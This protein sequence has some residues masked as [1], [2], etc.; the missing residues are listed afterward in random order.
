[1]PSLGAD[2]DEGTVL[3]WLV[4]PGATVH[5]GDIV[6]V[7]KTDKA[8]IEVE[9]FDD[10]VVGEL[11]VPVGETVAVGTPLA[12][13]LDGEAG[14]APTVT[15]PPVAPAPEAAPAPPPSAP[16]PAPRP[17][18]ERARVSPYARRLA[19]ERGVDVA[20]IRTDHGAPVLAA[21]VERA[22]ERAPARPAAPAAPLDQASAM[23]RAIANLMARSKREIPHYYLRLQCDMTDALG[24]LERVNAEQPVDR[25]ALPAVL[26]CKATAVAARTYP[27]LNGFWVD[28][29]FVPGTGVHLGVAI[30][31][32]GGG[33]IAPA[34]HDADALPLPDLMAALRDLTLRARSGRLRASEMSDATLTVTSLGDQGV[35][36]VFGVIYPPQ[37]AL[38]GFGRISSRPWVVDGEVVARPV[39]DL[40]LSA[41]HRATD[42]HV[43]ARF[44][45]AIDRLL[46]H[47]EEL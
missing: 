22:V 36:E 47:P 38:V 8:D 28:D 16:P 41:D 40:T 34:V 17:P 12:T 18:G 39:V 42:G 45:A 23:R 46:H 21:D 43:G 33:L 11:L 44:L 6:A 35:D 3:E 20:T 25:R 9:V 29:A 19:S 26:L 1:M 24:W 37:V 7:V 5:K 31:L 27:H 4:A 15:A 10:G 2:M 32:R 30:S 13:I 14:T